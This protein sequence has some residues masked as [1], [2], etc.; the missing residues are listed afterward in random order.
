MECLAYVLESKFP[1]FN[2]VSPQHLL[3]DA[4]YRMSCEHLDY[5]IVQEEER[6]VGILSEQDV[7]QKVF[8]ANRPLECMRVNDVMNFAVP[9]AD[10][11]DSLDFAMQILDR[12]NSRYI[13]VFDQLD[14]K[15]IVSENDLLRRSLRGK[16]SKGSVQ[17]LQEGFNWSY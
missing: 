4:L 15:G 16:E 9:V 3:Q 13:A 7:V 2:K 5:L 10:V 6:F 11:T 8:Q 1:Q 12:Y 14:F 17:V